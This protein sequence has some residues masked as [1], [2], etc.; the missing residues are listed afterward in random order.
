MVDQFTLIAGSPFVCNGWPVYPPRLGDIRDIGYEAYQNHLNILMVSVQEICTALNLSLTE[1]LAQSGAIQLISYIPDLRVSLIG[2]LRFFLRKEVCYRDDVGYFVDEG[3]RVYLSLAEIYAIRKVILSF[4]NIKD[5]V[6]QAPVS[7]KN[8][9]ARRTYEKIQKCKA[10]K[11]QKYAS[12][13]Y[14]AAME[15]PNLIGAVAAYS[16]SYNLLNIW[17][18]TIYQFYDQFARLDGKVQLEVISQRW[19]AWGKDKFDLAV[20]RTPIARSE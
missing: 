20:W 3:Q 2:S 14:N 9:R 12:A 16:P 6:D 8:E 18:L 4:C 7:F 15:L 19:A 11:R 10:A 1:G 17:G 13:Q 5:D